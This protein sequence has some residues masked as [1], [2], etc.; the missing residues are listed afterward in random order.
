M[1]KS[2]TK[3]GITIL[4]DY[5]SDEPED[6]RIIE[7]TAGADMLQLSTGEEEK[8]KKKLYAMENGDY[9]QTI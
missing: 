4:Y 7:V 6:I 8:L 1:I 5:Y 9:E 3:D 2:H